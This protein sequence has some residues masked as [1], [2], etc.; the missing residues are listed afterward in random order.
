MSF[1]R[2]VQL[3]TVGSK[4][5][6]SAFTQ[7]GSRS[8]ARKARSGRGLATATIV[9]DTAA[10]KDARRSP[11]VTPLCSAFVI[12]ARKRR[13]SASRAPMDSSSSKVSRHDVVESN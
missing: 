12:N 1:C 7:L 9:P 13:S 3:E 6:C 11:R 4:G 8:V 5:T 10:G 2:E